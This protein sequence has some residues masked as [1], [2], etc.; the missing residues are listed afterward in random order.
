MLLDKT[1]YFN[2]RGELTSVDPGLAFGNS[3]FLYAQSI[4]TT[5]AIRDHSLSFYS[6]HIDRLKRGVKWCFEKEVKSE[7]IED[8][9]LSSYS[10]LKSCKELAGFGD[11][12][13]RLTF[14]QRANG[15]LFPLLAFSPFTFLETNV[16]KVKIVS[17]VFGSDFKK[18]NIKVGDYRT[19]KIYEQRVGEALLFCDKEGFVTEGSYSNLILRAKGGKWVTPKHEF[20]LEGIA[21]QHGLEGLGI[22]RCEIHQS[23]LEKYEAAWFINALRGPQAILRIGDHSFKNSLKFH[24]EIKEVFNKNRKEKGREL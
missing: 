8:L 15:E 5:A 21:L 24:E 3:A 16:E 9:I 18:D 6:Q 12:K 20:V 1:F 2:E 23:E 14:I 10:S 17:E 11:W 19:S 7:F 13:F 4:F 22:E